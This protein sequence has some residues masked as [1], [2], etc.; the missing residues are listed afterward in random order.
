MSTELKRS[1][2]NPIL[3]PKKQ[4]V[5]ES[6]AV[7]NPCVYLENN[8]FQMLYRALSQK[9]ITMPNGKQY[10]HSYI[11]YANSNDGIV[12]KRRNQPI[13]KPEYDWEKLGCEDA[14]VVK[15]DGTYYIF[16]SAISLANI[17]ELN[18]QIAGATTSDFNQIE[19][20]GVIS[21]KGRGKASSLFPEKIDGK[22]AFLYTQFADSP[23]STVFY[24]Q[25]ESLDELFDAVKWKRIKKIPLLTPSSSAYR[26]PELGAPPIKTPDGWLLVYC[27]ESAKKEWFIGAALLDLKD[28]TKVLAKTTEPLLKPEA[29][30]ERRGYVDNVAFP[31]GAVVVKD[32]LYVYYGGADQ[33]C[34]LATCKLDDLLTS[35]A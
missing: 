33:G 35:L 29:S 32:K 27:P 14:R 23:R 34:C 4:N 19:K 3:A 1:K 31:Q 17:D 10:H 16:Y 24:A 26:G 7:M 11:G 22:Y 13:V 2:N 30:Y 6:K 25:V 28:P 12:F 21:L 5:W 18:V 8:N 9:C 15:I 20:L